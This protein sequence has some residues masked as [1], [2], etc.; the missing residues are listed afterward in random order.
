MNWVGFSDKESGILGYTVAVGTA[1]CL[2]DIYGHHDP[3][4]HLFD[5]SQ[6]INSALISPVLLSGKTN[7]NHW[8]YCNTVIHKDHSLI[9]GSQNQPFKFNLSPL[10]ANLKD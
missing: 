5:A 2:D 1:V 3:Q 8:F 7:W 4:S 6:W 9:F 10:L